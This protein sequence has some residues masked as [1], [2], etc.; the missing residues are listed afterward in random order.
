MLQRT[1]Q[2]SGQ[3]TSING[4]RVAD[5]TVLPGFQPDLLRRGE[6][7]RWRQ[8]IRLIPVV[9]LVSIRV[10]I[11]VSIL[12]PI[13]API[14]TTTKIGAQGLG[15]PPQPDLTS[16]ILLFLHLFCHGVINSADLYPMSMPDMLS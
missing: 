7:F 6:F 15:A 16:G 3:L 12:A 10:S 1:K 8:R 5:T 14:F 2:I 4:R 9:F 13:L 11:R